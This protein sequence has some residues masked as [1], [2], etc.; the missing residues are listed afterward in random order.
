MCC[1]YWGPLK[2]QLCKIKF[3]PGKLELNMSGMYTQ[4]KVYTAQQLHRILYRCAL[5]QR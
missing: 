5:V 4:E 1:Y 3:E 2:N